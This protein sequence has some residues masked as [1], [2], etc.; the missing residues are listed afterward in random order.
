[1]KRS[2]VRI[3]WREAGELALVAL[4]F[5]LG[6]GLNPGS[7]QSVFITEGPLICTILLAVFTLMMGLPQTLPARGLEAGN[8]FPDRGQIGRGRHP[9]RR[10]DAE[11]THLASLGERPDRR[12]AVDGKVDVPADLWQSVDTPDWASFGRLADPSIL[13]T[14]AGSCVP[15]MRGRLEV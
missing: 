11:R 4:A 10:A 14:V 3:P 7:S 1:M 15:V 2:G 9:L 6:Y 12:H 5:L 8:A 13:A